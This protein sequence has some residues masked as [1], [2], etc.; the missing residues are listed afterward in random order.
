M[1]G[2]CK[3]KMT[4]ILLAVFLGGLGVHSFYA[5]Y[6]LTGLVQLILTIVTAGLGWFILLPWI[7]IEIIIV[8]RDSRGIPFV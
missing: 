7:I 1:C 4:Y 3:S 6:T 8:N 5:G 2:P